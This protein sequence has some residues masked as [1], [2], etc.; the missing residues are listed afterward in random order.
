MLALPTCSQAIDSELA[1]E[2]L[3]LYQTKFSMV[4]GNLEQG[5]GEGEL[6]MA[7]Y[8]DW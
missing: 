7:I 8:K 2:E 3:H 6:P 1:L 4:M 5:L